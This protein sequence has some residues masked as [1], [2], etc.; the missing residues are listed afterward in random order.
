MLLMVFLTRWR[1]PASADGPVQLTQSI[2]REAKIKGGRGAADRRGGDGPRGTRTR[3]VKGSKI[4]P[5]WAK[6]PK[7]RR[8]NMIGQRD[9]DRTRLVKG[10]KA[11]RSVGQILAAGRAG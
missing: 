6:V 3:L 5:D 8:S 4:E 10:A 9:E 1:R 11:D 2:K 7:G